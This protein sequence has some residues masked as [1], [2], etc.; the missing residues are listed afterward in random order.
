VHVSRMSVTTDRVWTAEEVRAIPDLPDGEPY[1]RYEVVDGVLL[2]SPSPRRLH[3]RADTELGLELGMYIRRFPGV[4][5]LLHSPSDVELDPYSLVQPDLF[6]APRVNGRLGNDWRD[7]GR[8]VLAIEI[9]SPSTARNDRGRKR[10]KYTSAGIP[11]W[12]V[13]ID[14]RVFEVW[15]PGIDMP[16]IVDDRVEWQPDGAAEPFVLDLPAFF[17]AVTGEP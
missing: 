8:P 13:D 7:M 14:A 17:L 10:R 5:E 1:T 2:V 15:T 3:Q 16:T 4:G 6:V 12:L 9:L 11:L